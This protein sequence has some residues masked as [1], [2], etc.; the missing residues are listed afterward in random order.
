MSQQLAPLREQVNALDLQLIRLLNERASVAQQIGA[1]KQQHDVPVFHPQREAQVIA[2]LQEVNLGPLSNAS[3]AV[4][5]GEIMSACRGLEAV[6]SVAYLGPA[7]TFSEG[8]AQ[9]YFGHAITGMPCVSLDEVFRS[10]E[11][12]Q[13]SYGVVPIENSSEGAVSRT[14]DLLLHSPL[15]M[16]GELAML[17]DHHLLSKTGNMEG[18]TVVRGH[19]QALAQCQRWLSINYPKLERQAVAS[20]AQA[21]LL[22]A[23]DASSAAIAG[24]AAARCYGLH[25]VCSHIQDDPHNR[26]RFIIIGKS[27]VPVTGCDQT[28]LILSVPNC[29]GAVHRMLA[30]LAEHGVSMTRFESRPVRNGTWEYYF[31]LDIEGH[32]DDGNVALALQ[33]LR[34]Q[35]A[36]YKLLGSY[37]RSTS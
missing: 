16:S 14:L 33:A 1:I 32:Q 7:G 3:V 24:D 28:S 18:V 29:A 26:T 22:A 21:A 31:Y 36:F 4:I 15:H 23:E 9:R 5:W 17:I 8:A 25:A 27:V 11:V 2:G 34:Q 6:L 37:P 10:V 30:P 35:S 12:G 13:A 20:N 19:A